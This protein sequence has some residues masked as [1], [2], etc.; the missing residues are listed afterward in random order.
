MRRIFLALIT[1]TFILGCS[2]VATDSKQNMEQENL[3]LATIWYQNSPEVK[4]LYYQGFNIAQERVQEF[5]KQK[6]DRPKAVVVDLD[7][8]MIDNSPFQGKMIETG[9]PFTPEMWDEW[10]TLEKAEAMPGAVEFTQFCKMQGIEVIY[11]SNRT[12]GQQQATMSNMHK[13]G[14][15]F[16]KPEN[17]YLKDTTSKKEPRRRRISENFDIILLLGDNLN[18]FAQVFEDR[19]EDWG[20]ANVDGQRQQFG[21]KFIVFP[22]PMYGEWEKNIYSYERV[23]DEETRFS[24]RRE[25]L[26]SF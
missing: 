26:K 18:D 1:S 11:L 5:Q 4:A 10:V 2:S 8:T 22:N 7:E 23:K 25:T 15:A 21:R 17:F 13:L 19:Y 12:V 24:M 16:V 6:S 14:F 20:K 9:K 3:T